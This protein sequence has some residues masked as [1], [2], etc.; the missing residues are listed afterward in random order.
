MTSSIYS[1]STSRFT[2]NFF[3]KTITGTKASFNKANK[4]CG[5]EYEELIAKIT[6]HPDFTLVMKEQKIKST[7]AKRTYNGLDFSFME[8]Y[9]STLKNAD[10][11]LAEYKAIK[12][13]AKEIGTAVF[14]MTKK[15]FLKTFGDEKTGF[16][17]DKANNAIFDFYVAQAKEQANATLTLLSAPTTDAQ[18]SI[19]A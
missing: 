1:N 9:I 4:G 16:D 5:I 19:P 12:N 18:S 8:K 10:S 17:M 11:M 7:R 15:W 3:E 13:E 2:L 6:A 14:P